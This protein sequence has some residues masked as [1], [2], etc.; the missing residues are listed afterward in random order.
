M[1]YLMHNFE[2]RLC[3]DN[4]CLQ[5]NVYLDACRVTVHYVCAIL[6]T[7]MEFWNDPQ[8][9]LYFFMYWLLRSFYRWLREITQILHKQA[10]V[11]AWSLNE[12]SHKIHEAHLATRIHAAQNGNQPRCPPYPFLFAFMNQCITDTCCAVSVLWFVSIMEVCAMSV[13]LLSHFFDFDASRAAFLG[14][15]SILS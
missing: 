3:N 10:E 14:Y 6:C 5:R 8:N 12:A 13:A 9:D 11:V 7:T 1:V 4:R 15:R 2:P